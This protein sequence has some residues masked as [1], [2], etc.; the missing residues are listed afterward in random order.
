MP[1]SLEQALLD[2]VSTGCALARRLQRTRLRATSK[3]DNSPVT[4]A[5]FA[6]QALIGLAFADVLGAANVRLAGEESLAML[7]DPSHRA[8]RD[9]VIAEVQRAR[10]DVSAEAVLAAIDLATATGGEDYWTVDPIDGTTG[11]V[12]GDQYSI[13][14]ARIR[15]GEVIF[16]ILGCPNVSPEGLY[17]SV[18][19][20]ESDGVILVAERGGGCWQRPDSAPC[21]GGTRLVRAPLGDI[22]PVVAAASMNLDAPTQRLRDELTAFLGPRVIRRSI[23]SQVKY[24]LL[25]RGE[26]DVYLRPQRL[27]HLHE[28]IW[29]H[30]AG[31]LVATEAGACVFDFDGRPLDFSHGRNLLRNRGIVGCAAELRAPLFRAIGRSTAAGS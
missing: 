10:A 9:A 29:D 21:E 15:R 12:R 23:D 25:A 4:I 24:G 28:H 11:F 30:A 22:G 20:G 17:D 5:D 8:V 18:P 6:V 19:P 13:A 1:E 27:G 7:D 31:A 2:A 26:V 3:A 14:L 16:G